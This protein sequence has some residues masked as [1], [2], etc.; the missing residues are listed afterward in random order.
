MEEYVWIGN[1][2]HHPAHVRHAHNVLERMASQYGVK[3]TIAGSEDG[4]IEPYL[5][6]IR[7]A[8]GRK[9][10]GIMLLGWDDPRTLEAVDEAID[11]GIPVVTVDSDL[12]GSKRLAHVGTDWFQMGWAMAETLR[13][14]IT[15]QGKVLMIGLSKLVNMKTGFRGFLNNLV[16]CREIDILRVADDPNVSYETVRAVVAG[17]LRQYDDLVGIAAFDGNSGPSAALAL[18]DTGKVQAVKLVCI[19]AEKA[20][21]KHLRTGAIDAAFCQR[22][23]SF[24]FHAFQMLYAYNHGS[25]ATAFRPGAINIPGS[26]YTGHI[27]VTLENIDTFESD[28]N[29]D[30]AFNRHRLSQQIDLL[31]SMVENIAEI[32][33]AT[34][35][36]GA[37]VYANPA[38]TR[39]CGRSGQEMK[40][41]TLDK[42]FHLTKKHRAL[43]E[44]CMRQGRPANFETLAVKG[45]GAMFPV[46]LSLSALHAETAIRGMV[47][48]AVDLTAS[49]KVQKELAQSENWLRLL[50]ENTTDGID[51][52]RYD[53]KTERLTLV[54]CND[55]YVEMTGRSREELMAAE[56]LQ[57]L[58][59]GMGCDPD[60]MERYRKGLPVHGIASWIRPDGKENYYEWTAMPI[61]MERELYLLGIDRD[62]TDSRLTREALARSENWLQLIL[63]H[64]FDGINVCEH[65]LKTKKRKLVMCNERFVEMSGRS[66]EELMA[67][68]SLN[69][70]TEG[71][72][73][74]GPFF[75]SIFSGQPCHGI[76]SW[77]RPDGKANYFEWTATKLRTENNKLYILGIDRDIT[78]RI[79]AEEALARSESWLRTIMEHATDGIDVCRYALE[80]TKRTLVTCNDRYVEMSGRSREELMAADNLNNLTRVLQGND[81]YFL[82]CLRKG[83]PCRGMSSWIRPDG[84]ENYYE[85]T[86]APL[87]IDGE[88]H[89]VGIDRDITE[90]RRADQEIHNLNERLQNIIDFLPDAT[91]VI[92]RDK[93]VIAW[94]HQLEKFL[95]VKKQRVLGKGQA[96]YA[97]AFNVKPGTLMIDLIGKDDWQDDPHYQ[98]IERRGNTLFAEVFV[99]KT[100][101]CEEIVLWA[102]ATPLLD[103]EGNITGA[104]ESIRDITDYKRAQADRDRLAAAI[105]QIHE[106][107]V[108]TDTKGKIEY[109][110]PAFERMTSYSRHETLGRN[111]A[112]IDSA[113]E[114][115]D[116]YESMWRTVADGQ[117]WSERIT[118]RKKDGTVYKKELTVSP[119]R[120]NAGKIINYV[121]VQ[122]DVTM[123]ETLQA[124]LLQA[125]KM[126][127]AGQLAGGVAHDFNNQLTVVKGYCELLLKDLA[128]N[129]PS[130]GPIE[131]IHKASNRAASLTSQ[132]LSFSRK[133]LLHPQIICL[134]DVLREVADTLTRII[135]EDI[136]LSILTSPD[137][138]NV[139]ADPLQ[140]QQAIMNLVLNARAAMPEGG[141]LRLETS[142][143][144]LSEVYAKWHIGASAG[145][146]V[147]LTVSDTGVGMDEETR[148][149]IFEPF[150]TT[151][152][153]GEGTGLG[154]A[155]VYGFVKQSGGYINVSSEVGRGTTVQIYLPRIDAEVK[156]QE[157][158]AAPREELTGDETILVAEDDQAVRQ[159]IV[160][161][162]RQYGYTVL[163]AGNAQEAL[164]LGEHYSGAIDLLISDVVMPGMNG[165]ELAAKLRKVRPKMP[166][167]YITG[168]TDRTTIRR[169]L[170]DGRS[171]LLTKPFEPH[172]LGQT[173][174]SLLDATAKPTAKKSPRQSA[175]RKATGEAQKSPQ[176]KK[177]RRRS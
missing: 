96:A 171:E 169:E 43:V 150:F 173:V 48:V 82:D 36:D 149:R 33:L 160:R 5:Q 26:I 98:N 142:N 133:Q 155:M 162:F 42:L 68:G 81:A 91:F 102:T 83:L 164:P 57:Q 135:A 127:A 78:E 18:E 14:L 38:A 75:K 16:D 131:E 51:V 156:P 121:T 50:M 92:D 176:A 94:N 7:D 159:M 100:K 138:G 129:N 97:K 148:K 147:M 47:A 63:K 70:L 104:I 29:L 9:V 1:L 145:P 108:I 6:A 118:D 166:V 172:K 125:Q 144:T 4:V 113:E 27:P 139:R 24:T 21:L 117:I 111:I 73:T 136:K 40:E 85:W 71:K 11:R 120:D 31:S 134:N 86:A 35:T 20:H 154:L 69:K 12:P 130:Y 30:E 76:S 39:L 13:E 161:F 55:R 54:T 107:V 146:H 25:P 140:V 53:L 128:P 22:R 88:L 110:N 89:I 8:A 56:D 52:C 90:R 99:P 77:I 119:L 103:S 177:R 115:H 61:R 132:L 165:P 44:R 45:D 114:G 93:K 174:R 163:E 158:A 17:Y 170:A 74:S 23:E 28:Q 153:V 168:Y 126:E 10:A 116:P 3:V 151:K 66:R 49:K 84:K 34:D 124:R 143:V 152:P 106:A 72:E 87:Y 109:V 58:T 141:Q 32:T 80:T 67:V 175:R 2:T 101:Q 15:G 62:I 19:D 112:K 157:P 167:L 41:L 95:G 105:E 123:Q 79:L 137:L 37:I 122:R 59:K 46:Q 64:S 60:Y 65:D